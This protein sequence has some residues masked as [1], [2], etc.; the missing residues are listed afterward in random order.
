MPPPRWSAL[1]ARSSS[2][3][4]SSMSTSLS[5]MML[6]LKKSNLRCRA[7]CSSMERNSRRWLRITSSSISFM[8]SP[9][10]MP[11]ALQCPTAI[12]I[13]SLMAPIWTLVKTLSNEWV[14]PRPILAQVVPSRQAGQPPTSNSIFSHS[15][16]L[17]WQGSHSWPKTPSSQSSWNNRRNIKMPW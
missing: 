3:Q 12:F 14:L 17:L 5:Q 8:M 9:S 13:M 4:F 10:P 1:D 2:L 6:I 16:S 15:H 11:I 7:T